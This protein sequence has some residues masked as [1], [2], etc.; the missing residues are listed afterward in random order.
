MRMR[1]TR[2][3]NGNV[4][5]GHRSREALAFARLIGIK[6]TPNGGT[7]FRR[8]RSDISDLRRYSDLSSYSGM[9]D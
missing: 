8:I 9:Y 1:I 3:Y 6:Q 5:F 2:S 4:P 7:L